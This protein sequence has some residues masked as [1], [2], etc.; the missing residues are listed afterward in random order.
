MRVV[1]GR[2]RGR[3]LRT[4]RGLAVRPTSDRVKTAVF[5]ILGPTVRG[6]RVLDLFAG[7]GALGIE[8]LSRGAEKATFVEC[9]RGPLLVLQ[10]NLQTLGLGQEAEVVQAEAL[11]YLRRW[12]GPVQFDIVFADPPYDFQEHQSLL[13][14]VAGKELLAPGGLLVLEH[15]TGLEPQEPGGRLQLVRRKVFG[16]TTVSWFAMHGESHEHG[17]LS[18]DV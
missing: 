2:L 5:D 17:H 4:V 15:R 11:H 9:A 13:A 18:R 3:A 1:A 6:A 7:S 14:L 10:Q 12:Q 16:I 8:A